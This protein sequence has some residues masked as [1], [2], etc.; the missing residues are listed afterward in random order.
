MIAGATY[1]RIDDA[2]L[3][4]IIDGQDRLLAVRSVVVC[5]GQRPENALAAP[6]G[7]LGGRVHAIGGAQQADE[8]DAKRAIDQG[9]R[10]AARL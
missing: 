6:L 1:R 9:V 2:G 7:H 5:A 10:L 4:V 3:H 8:R